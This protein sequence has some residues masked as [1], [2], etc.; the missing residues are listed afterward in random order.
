MEYFGSMGLGTTAFVAYNFPC[1]RSALHGDAIRAA[2][3]FDSGT[4]RLPKFGRG[5]YRCA[6][7]MVLFFHPVFSRFL[8]IP[9]IVIASEKSLPGTGK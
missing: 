1:Y 9:G 4:A 2:I 6:N 5:I 7:R 8:A 3:E